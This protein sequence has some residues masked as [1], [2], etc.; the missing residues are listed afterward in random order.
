MPVKGYRTFT[1]RSETAEKLEKYASMNGLKVAQLVN[2]LAQELETDVPFMYLLRAIKD[3]KLLA[4]KESVQAEHLRDLLVRLYLKLQSAFMGLQTILS[5]DAPYLLR[6][7]G[8]VASIFVTLSYQL[9]RLEKILNEAYPRGWA[10]PMPPPAACGFLPPFQT[11]PPEAQELISA[12]LNGLLKAISDQIGDS[13]QILEEAKPYLPRLWE[14][15]GE[16]LRNILS[17]VKKI[18]VE[19]LSA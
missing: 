9:A 3:A 15:V 7:K 16:A 17:S 11:P 19:E 18:R 10:A 14:S 13:I 4:L 8:S 1:I 2:R 12:Q 6:V 5:S